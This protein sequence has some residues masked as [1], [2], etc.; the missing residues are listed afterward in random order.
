MPTKLNPTPVL[1]TPPKTT[2]PT[3][4]STWFH[5]ASVA[6]GSTTILFSLT[7]AIYTPTDSHTRL[8][9]L[10]AGFF[11]YLIADLIS[12]IYH[13]LIDN[14]GDASTPFV[15]SH[16][17][18]FQGHHSLPWAITKREFASN[19]HVGARVITYLTVPANMMWHENPV[20]MGFVGVAGGGMMFGSQ[21][22]AWAH[23]SRGKLPAVVVALQDVGVFVRQSEHARHHLPPYDGGYC[24]VSGV[25]NRVLDEYKV[26][27]GLEKVVFFL[28]GV[29]PRSWS[30]GN[31]GGGATAAVTAEDYFET[32]P[33]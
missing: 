5:R 33:P 6:I 20:V 27:L 31:S 8:K 13:W 12:G 28:F 29:K 16:I 30:E 14:Y 2:G 18:A 15:G 26:F 4:K 9:T 17:E 19:L 3:T 32:S 21:I 23:V 24:V 22:H 7:K 11:G 25:W 1:F 10:I